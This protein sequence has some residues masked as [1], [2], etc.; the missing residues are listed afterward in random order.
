MTEG[1]GAR[2]LTNRAVAACRLGPPALGPKPAVVIAVNPTR[3]LDLGATAAVMR[4][5]LDARHDGAGILLIHSDLDELLQVADRILVMSEGRL[6]DSGWPV[7][8]REAI[9]ELMLGGSGVPAAPGE[10]EFRP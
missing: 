9:G 6:I 1:S 3:G 2:A 7:T 8:T 4:R 5:L 10:V